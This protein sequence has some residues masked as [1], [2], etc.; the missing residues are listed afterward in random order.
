MTLSRSALPQ[1]HACTATV[2]G[3][4]LDAGR[5]QGVASLE[6]K[7]KSHWRI[8]RGNSNIYDLPV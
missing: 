3:D 4:E 6:G 2:F 7:S 8:N 5:F 1:A